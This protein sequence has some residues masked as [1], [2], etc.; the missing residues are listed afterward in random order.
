MFQVCI[1]NRR[2]RDEPIEASCLDYS[3]IE[4]KTLAR[5]RQKAEAK[6]KQ[7]GA[8]I[9]PTPT[10]TTLS[11]STT[12]TTTTTTSTAKRYKY[13]ECDEFDELEEVGEGLAAKTK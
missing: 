10:S 3:W 9:K 5:L 13:L 4:E 1:R 8:A 6:E 7:E 2:N 11:S 12:T